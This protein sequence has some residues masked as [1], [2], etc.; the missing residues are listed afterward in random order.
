MLPFRIKWFL[1][2]IECLIGPVQPVTPPPGHFVLDAGLILPQQSK[3]RIHT[4]VCVP[5]EPS[6]L[7]HIDDLLEVRYMFRPDMLWGCKL[8]GDIF[9]S[10]LDQLVLQKETK[11]LC[12]LL[13]ATRIVADTVVDIPGVLFHEPAS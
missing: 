4:F 2:R 9:Q 10:F 13:D 12:K 5:L 11:F 8:L 6:S 7:F 1:D 3:Q